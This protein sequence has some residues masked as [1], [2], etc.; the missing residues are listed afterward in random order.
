M[1]AYGKAATLEFF[2]TCPTG[3]EPLL[4]EELRGLGADGVRP[5]KGM[6]SFAG[7]LGDA[8][9]AC[10]WS[11]IASRVVAVIARVGAAD[12]DELYDGIAQIPWE[13]HLAQN[14]TLS[15]DAHG[16]NKSLKNTHFVEL[17]TKDAISDHLRRVRGAAP[18]ASKSDGGLRVVVRLRG[19]RA[20]VGIDL[21]GEALFRRETARAAVGEMSPIRP[22]YAAALLA[23]GGWPPICR[24]APS[25]T[26]VALF[27]GSGTI[28]CEA[29][30][31]ARDVAPQV[32]RSRWGF[33][34]WAKHDEKAWSDLLDEA[35][36]RAEA[37]A[38]RDVRVVLVDPRRGELGALAR[39]LRSVG[40]SAQVETARD[41]GPLGGLGE[42]NDGVLVA[43][44]LSW[45]D[46][47]D[48]M[49][50]RDAE[51]LLASAI[52]AFDTTPSTA[53][54]TPSAS[55]DAI[56]GMDP[57]SVVDT[58][59]GSAP[60]T[61][62]HYPTGTSRTP[63]ARVRLADGEEIGVLV[64]ASE[65]FAARLAKVARLRAKWA[66]RE[67]VSCYRV[68]DADLP[69]YA[70]SIDLYQGVD[71]GRWVQA[72]EYQAPREVDP[73]LAGARLQDALAITQK[74]LKVDQRDVFCQVRSRSKGGSQ[75]AAEAE[76][77]T[78]GRKGRSG[79]VPLPKG[80]HLVDEGGLTF[81]V[82]FSARHDCGIFLDTRDVRSMIREMAKQT[83][84]SKRFLN[85]FAYTGTATCYAA[86]GGM[87]YTTTVDLSAPSLDWARRNMARNGFVGP[88]HEFVQADVIKWVSET[89]RTKNRWD[90]VFCD[91]PTF[92]N[93]AR[94]RGAFDVQRD[95]AELLI[96]V[97]RLLTRGDG[98]PGGGGVCV[99]CCN[100]RNFSPDVEKL[101]R[102][103]VAIEDVTARTIPEDFARNPKIH[104]CYLVR[105]A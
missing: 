84:G 27:A 77:V 7:E 104:H 39:A 42:K 82:N 58:V 97:S 12:A 96:G 34:G 69:D 95:H 16:T 75:Y 89:R 59:V 9:R 17:R 63:L 64:P 62:R 1:T 43:C 79:E 38:E 88:E 29:V 25:V 52:D 80:A 81:E 73:A 46:P 19:E 83:R 24:E 71:G 33:D 57:D 54:L 13:E 72:S 8:Y 93:S 78:W 37:E 5:L 2:A 61:I 74:V 30:A 35:D 68:Y 67:D 6:V 14:T 31:Q 56:L 87:R 36:A 101:A 50:L 65:Q 41:V 91:V 102:A 66:R 76:G 15:I 4:A 103:G 28:V 18:V 22:D 60:H 32:L 47:S 53:A 99:F 86:D 48:A 55:I 85:L 23:A 11:R 94:M 26:L 70:L 10:L 51:D 40:L 45:T 20:T 49:A 44:D 90:L 21:S 100:L 3:F 98:T 105:R 92:S